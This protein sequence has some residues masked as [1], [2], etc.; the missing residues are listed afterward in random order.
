MIDLIPIIVAVLAFFAISGVAFVAGQYYVRA[1]RLG[2]RLPALKGAAGGAATSAVADVV[3]RHFDEKRFGVDETL[4]GQLRLNL[5]R[6]G[7]FRKDAINFYVLGRLASAALMPIIAYVMLSIATPDL[8]FVKSSIIILISMGLGIIGPDGFI[9]RRGKRLL[10]AEYRIVFPDFLDLLVVCAN[11]GL[12]LEG[13]VDRITGEIG[14]RNRF[15]GTN[16]AKLSAEMRVGRS[17]VEALDA[18][19]DRL[20][21]PEAHSLVAV[22]RQSSEFGSD[23][24]EALSVFSDELREKRLMRAQEQANKLS[25]KMLAPL[26]LCIFPLV[27]MAV[28]LP[29]AVKIAT[30]FL[31]GVARSAL[32]FGMS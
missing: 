29:L 28:A 32:S 26:A 1:D 31:P 5:V 20:V 6:A 21:I 27:I 7:Y 10:S 4:R 25:V 2:R 16:L 14:K 12:S 18:L 3:A 15:F 9:S 30:I 24:G 11:A 8:S 22:L 23:V 13:S 19:A 17:F